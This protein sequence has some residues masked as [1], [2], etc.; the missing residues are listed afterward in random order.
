MN[1]ES[2]EPLCLKIILLISVSYD[3]QIDKRKKTLKIHIAS[4]KAFVIQ[5]YYEHNRDG[6]DL[7]SMQ[8]GM[9]SKMSIRSLQRKFRKRKKS[10]LENY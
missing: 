6:D 8:K 3:D 5:S 4:R 10:A 2:P 7:L 1:V 9:K